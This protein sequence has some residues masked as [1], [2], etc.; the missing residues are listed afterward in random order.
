MNKV[1]LID[2]CMIGTGTG[3]GIIGAEIKYQSPFVP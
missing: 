3:G 2:S 1:S